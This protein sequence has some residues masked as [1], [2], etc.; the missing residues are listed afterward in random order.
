MFNINEFNAMLVR[1]NF[2]RVDLAK[3]LGIS[4]VSLY[5]RLKN[6]GEFTVSE[7]N[8]MI[9]LFGKEEVFKSLFGF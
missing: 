7:I 2:T 5:K 9:D 4:K 8:T 3:K 6:N 1:R